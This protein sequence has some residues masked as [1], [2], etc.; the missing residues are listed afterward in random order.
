L[1]SLIDD[2]DDDPPRRGYAAEQGAEH[3]ER[4][5]SLGTPTILGIFFAL[6]LVCAGIFGLGYSMGRKSAQ[7]SG[8]DQTAASSDSPTGSGSAKP[9]AGSLFGQPAAPTDAPA[10]TPADDTSASA[11]SNTAPAVQPDASQ[12]SPAAPAAAQTSS[13]ATPTDGTATGGDKTTPAAPQAANGNQPPPAGNTQGATSFMVQIA[14]VSTQ[15]IA[16][17]EIAALKK[18]GYDVVIRHEPQDQLLHIQI[19]PF[20]NRK[21]AEA[22]R[23]N[24]LAHGFNAIVK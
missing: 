21:D 8:T 23:L 15:E 5:I 9:A 16:E 19:G 2:D 14:A 17:M 22:M 1:N 11:A 24:V 12:T 4:E 20:A 18:D 10:A 3:G 6:A 13:K 7:N